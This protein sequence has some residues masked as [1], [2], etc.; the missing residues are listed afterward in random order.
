M[1]QGE[2]IKI[3]GQNFA[4][5]D[6]LEN[7]DLFI[8]SEKCVGESEYGD[9]N[10][11]NSDLRDAVC[12]W[13]GEFENKINNPKFI[14]PRTIDLTTLDGY[15][16]YGST[17]KKAAPL[18]L[19]EAR[20]YAEYIPKCDTAYWLATV[21]G[22]PDHLGAANALYVNTSGNWYDG[23]CPSSR[24]VRPALVVNPKIIDKSTVDLSS[25]STEDLMAELSKR[26]K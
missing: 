6:V 14:K 22:A 26:I 13:L 18:T 24:G 23:Y 3:A 9:P 10:Y 1:K 21:W 20:K 12:K 4:V 8:L 11:A 15:T 17:E 2:I 16:G 25:V 19:D 7:G 5:L